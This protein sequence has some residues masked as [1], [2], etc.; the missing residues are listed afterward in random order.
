MILWRKGTMDWQTNGYNHLV[1]QDYEQ[2]IALYEQAIAAEPEVKSHYWL[3]GLALLLQGQEAEAQLVWLMVMAEGEPEQVNCWTAELVQVLEAE[4]A[5]QDELGSG[6]VAWAIR[7]HIRELCPDDMNNLLRILLFSI[8]LKT[9]DPEDIFTSGLLKGLQFQQAIVDEP[10]LLQTLES[11]LN[12]PIHPLMVD[13]V[14]AALPHCPNPDRFV[15]VVLIGSLKVAHFSK[16]PRLAA[17]LAEFCLRAK[18]DNLEVLF[19]LAPFYQKSQQYDQGIATARRAVELSDNLPNQV[20]ASYLLLR[21]LMNAGGYWEEA[22][23]VLQQHEALILQVIQARPVPLDLVSNSQLY[24]TI[25]FFAYFRDEPKQNRWL[26]EQLYEICTANMQFHNQEAFERYQQRN[27]TARSQSNQQRLK[28]GYICHCFYEHSVGWLARWLIRHHDL[29]RFEVHLFFLNYQEMNDSVQQEYLQLADYAHTLGANRIEIADCIANSNIDI[30]IDLDSITL[31]ITCGVMSL[32]PAPIQVTWLGWDASGISTIDYF[33]ADPYVL[34]EAAQEYYTE[35][36]WRL[37]ETYIAVDGFEVGVPTLR[38]D[39]LGIPDDAVVY[40]SAQRGYKRHRD[41]AQLQMKILKAV[42]NS[43][44]LIKGLADQD[45]VKAFFTQ[46]AEAAGVECDR[47]IFLPD[48]P[49]E[50]IHRA[51]LAIADIVLDTYPYNGATTTLETLWMGIPLV[52]RVGEQFAARNSYTM[53]KN[54]G[55]EEGISWTDEEYI[56]WGIRLGT[57]ITLRQQVREKLR[58]SRQTSPLWNAKQFTREM[59]RAYEQMWANR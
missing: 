26:Q 28:I 52:T 25:Y 2:A 57:D 29:D 23:A 51:N 58:R 49:S 4:A 56:E 6:E 8:H 37:P 24:A 55:V 13:L 10:L 38:R 54:V 45:A 12:L 21:G 22:I 30:L 35:K 18:P 16:Q 36:I 19:E 40:L 1:N 15:K 53:L 50:T 48:V 11:V 41:T 46:L 5:R 42:P 44:F 7:Q 59:E 43:Y 27:L 34:P 3:M 39:Q 9:F 31:D 17:R 14:E 20:F 47:L 33:I 32:K